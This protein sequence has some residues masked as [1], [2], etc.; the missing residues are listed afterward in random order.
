[1]ESG[2]IFFEPS[3][4]NNMLFVN[5]HSGFRVGGRTVINM[6]ESSKR[7]PFFSTAEEL[8]DDDYFDEQLPEKKRRLT[9][10]QVHMLEKS[11]ET[12]NK[13]E[14]ERKTQLAKK[15]NLQP[16]Q[17]AVWFQNRRAR[18][19]TKQL[20][21]DY[22]QL[23]SSYDSLLSDYDSI[24][25]ENDKLKS[26]LLSLTEKMQ[27]EETA[28]EPGQKPDPVTEVDVVQPCLELTVKVEDR[29]SIGSDGSAVVDDDGRQL[30]DSGDSY[31]PD[32]DYPDCIAAVEGIN[33]EEDDGSDDG[34]SYFDVFAVEQ[35][36]PIG[37]CIWS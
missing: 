14:P 29:L 21:R 24:L 27:P 17:V 13:L 12:E 19:K 30:L 20:E 36:E 34:R 31:F 4:Q 3:C 25:K 37:W 10:E 7:R 9:P 32:N 1:M 35:Q 16:R 28:G 15:L 11:F 22:D 33:S 8:Y 18:W 6:E 26:E 5:S 23:K 2:R